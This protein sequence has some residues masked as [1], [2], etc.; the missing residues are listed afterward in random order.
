ML[1]TV[2]FYRHQRVN[3]WDLAVMMVASDHL[4]MALDH[5]DLRHGAHQEGLRAEVVYGTKE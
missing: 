5:L 4:D 2:E 3:K 1:E